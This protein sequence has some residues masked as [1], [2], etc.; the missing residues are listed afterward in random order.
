MT[1]PASLTA[2]APRAPA[3]WLRTALAALGWTVLYM[4]GVAYSDAFLV[5]VA[6]VTLFWPSAGVAFALVAV[7]GARWALVIPV[8]VV[9]A[10]ATLARVPLEFIPYSAA[11]NLLG[12]LVG[13]YVY[14]M[15]GAA[16]FE[17]SAGAAA[18]VAGGVAMAAAAA[19]IGTV[20]LL[21]AGMITADTFGTAY[22]KWAMGD[23]LG[24]L[25]I[26]PTL[27]VTA[28]AR[29]AEDR[30]APLPATYARWPE[31]I[32]W[33]VV[34][35]AS[36]GF[37]Y[38]TATQNS[39]YALGMIAFPL[40][41]LLWSAY[42]YPPLFT[43]VGTLL[44]IFTV[45]TL[46]GFGLGA[47][48]VPRTLLDIVLLLGFLNLFAAL[49]LVL[50]AS[51]HDQRVQARRALRE[52]VESAARQ[53]AELERLVAERTHQL[54]EANRQLEHASQTDA[55]TGLRNRRYLGRQLPLDLAFYRREAG[56]PHSPPH[57]LLFALVD[58]DHFKRINDQHGHDVGDLAIQAVAREG[59]REGGIVG[60]LGGEEFA[61]GLPDRSLAAAEEL[62]TR[63][64]L[65]CAQIRVR[66]SRGPVQLTCS[67]GVSC[68]SEGETVEGLLKRADIA[69]Y[70]AKTSGRNRVVSAAVDLVIAQ[71]G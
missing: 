40:A 56:E 50:M 30:D 59:Q 54:D 55:L 17:S 6:K 31:R 26:A 24:V 3:A 12:A 20:G 71:A 66:G 7:H 34:Y 36:Y 64:R 48:Q 4:L 29:A 57:A 45:T 14:A 51:I 1:L 11:S 58:I 42:R 19:A 68:W 18:F 5:G 63:I 39:G 65:R 49:P 60:R 9:L 52:S 23:L 33:M 38:W 61:I 10:H 13:A 37:V 27:L 44:A 53:Q 62:A 47:F 16:R 41:L 35:V 8:A 21:A 46:T 2:H 28:G 32:A 69:L 67:F 25:C 70:E 15:R 43:A 22:V